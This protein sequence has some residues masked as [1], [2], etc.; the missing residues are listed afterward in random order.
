MN[1]V[2]KHILVVE[3]D[4]LTAAMIETNFL[5]EG[6]SV[7]LVMDGNKAIEII[8][9]KGF[10]L[11]VLD[12]MLPGKNGREIL[13]AVRSKD[14]KTPVMMLTARTETHLKVGALN[15]GAD[16]YLAKPFHVDELMARARALIRRSTF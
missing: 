5:H 3:D 9:T 16:D 4:E 6:F 13:N 10:D 8:Q 7:T 2:S 12:Y 14:T 15:D 1:S 11:I